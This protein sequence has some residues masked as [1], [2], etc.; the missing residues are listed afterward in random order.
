MTDL[1]YAHPGSA[2]PVFSGLSGQLR[3]GAITAIT[4]G[5]GIGK[6]SLADILAGINLPTSGQV[7]LGGVPLTGA[8]RPAWRRQVTYLPQEP[9]II[10]D[11]VR[12]NLNLLQPTPVDDAGLCCAIRQ[13][14]AAFL[15]APP[16]GLDARLGDGGINL[17]GGERQRL[18]LARALLAPRPVLILDETTSSLD[19]ETEQAIISTLKALQK[20]HLVIV[21]SHRPS[22]TAIAGQVI[23][24]GGPDF[25]GGRTLSAAT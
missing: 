14:G 22:I 7:T 5:S 19:I 17:S 2:H 15:L 16:L 13:A 4:G 23:N 12:G 6:S 11:T 9:F 18:Q 25:Q 1:G 20:D 8:S 3:A 21:I 10:A 24:I